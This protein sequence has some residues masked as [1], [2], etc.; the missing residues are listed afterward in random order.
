MSDRITLVEVGPRDGL[1]NEP[2]PVSTAIK[3][4]LVDRLTDAGLPVIEAGAFVSPKWVPQ[5]AGSDEVFAGITRDPSVDYP[6]LVPNLR[7]LEAA[8]RANLKTIAIFLSASE[9]FSQR[10]INCSIAKSYERVQPVVAAAQEAGIAVRAYIS[11]VIGCPY[12]GAIPT[13][14]V[15][16][17]AEHLVGMGI[18]ELSLGDTI[19]VGTPGTIR[20]MLKTVRSAVG[21]EIT[22]A[23]HYHDTYGQALSNI[24]ASLEDGIRVFDSSVAG[25]GGCPY[26]PGAGG[27]VPT[28]DV[29]YMLSDMGFEFGVDLAKL[30]DIGH[31]I[32]RVIDRSNGSR[33]TRAMLATRTEP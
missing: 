20:P 24:L 9:T 29:V 7:G 19:G 32:C 15:A 16:A 23:G 18:R 14:A 13:K 8:Q 33:V 6:A 26:A 12:E 17:V 3:V 21:D 2:K 31:W 10:N 4:E 11:C 28:E 30:V 1:Q 25:L 22:L 5:M 27:N